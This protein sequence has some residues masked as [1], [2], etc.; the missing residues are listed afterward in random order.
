MDEWFDVYRIFP[1]LKGIGIHAVNIESRILIN[2]LAEQGFK[3]YIVNGANITDE[4]TFFDEVANAFQF[5][6]YFG[7]NWAAWDD[8]LN[9][10][11]AET[12]PKR[13]AII[14]DHADQ[15]FVADTQTFLQAVCDLNDLALFFVHY[16]R[17]HPEHKSD[18]KQIEFFLTGEERGFIKQY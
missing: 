12:I 4:I 8:S 15:S 10:E 6:S 3:I 18:Q 9:N 7:H 17:L 5:P 11:F 16:S 1:K 13:T 2:A 14:W